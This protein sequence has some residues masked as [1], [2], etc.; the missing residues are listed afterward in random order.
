LLSIF[1]IDQENNGHQGDTMVDEPSS[2]EDYTSKM[3]VHEVVE[4]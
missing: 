2:E 3:I 4:V 1:R